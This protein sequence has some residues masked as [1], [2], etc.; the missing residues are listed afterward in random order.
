MV[1][2]ISVSM[3]IGV[4]F[5]GLRGR[6]SKKCLGSHMT[7]EAGEKEDNIYFKESNGSFR[8]K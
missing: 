4:F 7:E 2:F 3:P 8:A 1:L 5:T 6:W